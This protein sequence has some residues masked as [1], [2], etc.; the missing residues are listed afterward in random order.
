MPHSSESVREF[1]QAMGRGDIPAALGMFDPRIEWNE[2]ENFIYADRNPYIG[3]QAVLE[4]VF[5]RLGGEWDNFSVIPDQILDAGDTAVAFGRYRGAYKRTGVS[6]NA[7][8]VHVFTVKDGK[9]VRFQQ[10]TDTA[11]FR[12]ASQRGSSANA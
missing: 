8:F 9:I 12:D 7:Q 6:V 3:P 4:G 5:A 10:Y 1:Y 2:A 11:Q